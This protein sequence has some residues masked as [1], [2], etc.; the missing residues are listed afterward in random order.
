M[1]KRADF[2]MRSTLISRDFVAFALAAV[3]LPCARAQEDRFFRIVGPARTAII[4]GSPTGMLTWTNWATGITCTVQS[5]TRPN[6]GDWVDYLRVPISNAVTTVQVFD[7]TPLTGMVL[8]PAGSYTMGDAFGEGYSDEVPAHTVYVSS[9]YMDKYEV[10]KGL[11][12]KV[13]VW[14]MTNGYSFAGSG[15]GTSHPVQGVSWYSAVAWCNARSQKEGLTPCYYTNAA[16]TAVYKIGLVNP[17]VNWSANGYRLPTEAEWEKAARGGASG[18][19]FPWRDTDNI[20]HSR[21]NY[22]AGNSQLYDLSYAAGYH[23]AFYTGVTPYTAPVG[24]LPAN[25]YGLYDMA[26]N[27]WEWCWDWYQSD[28][29]SQAG[30]KQTDPRGPT[31]PLSFRVERGGGWDSFAFFCR[32]SYRNDCYATFGDGDDGFRCV[33]GL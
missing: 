10:T 18:R 26:G 23:P 16:L 25:G 17:Y 12:D 14:G 24:S 3:L 13:K 11:W 1:S 9:F 29:Y 33:R 20:Q 4:S 5:A 8:I 21:A 19:R 32:T 2:A 15:N 7:P 6:A 30:A 22:N 31:G 27:V 28:W